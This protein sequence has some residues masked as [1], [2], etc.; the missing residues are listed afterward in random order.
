MVPLCPGCSAPWMSNRTTVLP[1]SASVVT[2]DVASGH[3]LPVDGPLRPERL[4]LLARPDG[5]LDPA[6]AGLSP[7]RG[8]PRHAH[9]DAVTGRHLSLA[10]GR[11]LD[12]HVG[13]V[14]PADAPVRA[15]AEL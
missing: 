4:H 15:D 13:R 12:A 10:A 8:E 9:A 11:V 14:Q 6:G 2:F 7:H 1:S 3:R 5:Q